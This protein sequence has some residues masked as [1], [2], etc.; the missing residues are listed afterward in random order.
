MNNSISLHFKEV[1]DSQRLWLLPYLTHFKEMWFI[2][3]WGTALALIFWHRESIDF[4]F[5]I[6]KEID[7]EKLF[8]ECQKIFSGAEIIKTFEE[9]NTLY[10]L[11]NGVKI[12]FFSYFH[13]TIW[14]VQEN[15]FLNIYSIEDISAMKL[16]AIQNRATNKDYVDLYYIVQKMWL[17][18]TLQTFFQK[19]WNIVTESYLLKSLIYFDDIIEE[20][21]ILKDNSLSFDIVKMYLEKEVKKYLDE[22]SQS[23]S[24]RE[25]IVSWEIDN[26]DNISWTYNWIQECIDSLKKQ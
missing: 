7:T 18:K 16:W 13:K 25:Y 14:T 23:D 3:W 17:E 6:N 24:L 21:L 8:I 2:L 15:E 5:F 12:S 9:K 26:E 10:I 20:A 22:Y 19:F 1:L 4:D 11:V